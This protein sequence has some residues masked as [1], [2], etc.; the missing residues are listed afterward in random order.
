[1]GFRSGNGDRSSRWN[2]CLG[3]QVN[4]LKQLSTYRD[5]ASFSLGNI[6]GGL[7][8]LAHIGYTGFDVMKLHHP[9]EPHTFG[10][11]VA[12]ILGGMAAHQKYTDSTQTGSP[13]G[14]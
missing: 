13:N 10:I 14:G 8:L 2:L 11:G 7:A 4:I 3:H 12:T 5:N 6:G 1:M 9:F